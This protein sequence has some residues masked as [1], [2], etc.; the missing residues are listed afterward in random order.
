MWL[1]AFTKACQLYGLALEMGHFPW[2]RWF[3]TV[4][5]P[6]LG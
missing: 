6:A 1:A 4:P 5:A 2:S 3:G